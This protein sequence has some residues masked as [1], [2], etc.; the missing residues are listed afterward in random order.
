MRSPKLAAIG[1]AT[2]S[3]LIPN[4]WEPIITP[5]IMIPGQTQDR[6]N[7]V[8]CRCV[9]RMW[10]LRRRRVVLSLPC[11]S[12]A[13]K[14]VETLA[15]HNSTTWWAG[16]CPSAIQPSRAAI[17]EASRPSTVAWSCKMNMVLRK[18]RESYTLQVIRKWDVWYLFERQV[19]DDQ[20]PLFTGRF[21]FPCIHLKTP[22]RYELF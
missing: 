10:R 4:R 22:D 13:M 18:C 3:G 20:H 16:I 8:V 17:V 11:S 9:I 15:E 1:V 21:H 12:E 5:T 2:L 6:C 14:A 19:P 7:D